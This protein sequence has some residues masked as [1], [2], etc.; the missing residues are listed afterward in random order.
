[1]VISQQSAGSDRAER[2]LRQAAKSIYA[3]DNSV[4][5][6]ITGRSHI[7]PEQYKS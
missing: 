3:P 7:P 6:A 1:M 2:C 4:I 5:E